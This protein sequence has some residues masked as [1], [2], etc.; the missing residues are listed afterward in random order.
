MSIIKLVP[1]YFQNYN[2]VANPKKTFM[3]SSSGGTTGSINLFANTS[4]SLKDLDP[5]FAIAE[6]GFDDNFIDSSRSRIVNIMAPSDVTNGLGLMESYLTGVNE[7]PQG[8][9]QNKRQEV[10]RFIPGARLDKN[11]GR[12]ATIQKILY[13][14]YQ[15]EYQNLEWAYTN[16]NCLHFY[17]SDSVPSDSALIYPAGTGA[18]GSQDLNVYAPSGSFTFD[19]YFKPKV[20][21]SKAPG[22]VYNPGTILHMSSCYAISAVSGTHKGRDGLPNAFRIL[23]QLSQSA[24]VA[25]SSCVIGNKNVTSAYGD[26][27]LMFATSDNSLP[28]DQWSHVSI[29]WPGKLKNGGTGSIYINGK[30]DT[31]FVI[32]SGSVMQSYQAGAGTDDPNALF[33]GNYYQGKNFG[34]EAIARYFNSKV[35]PEQGLTSFFTSS[36]PV[37]EDPGGGV[38]LAHPL[39]GELHEIKIY[40][41]EKSELEI[42]RMGRSGVKITRDLL[43]YVP[44]FFVQETR[45]RN[46]LQTPFFDATGSSEDPF[47]IALSFGVGGREINLENFSREFIRKEYPRLHNL[48]SSRIDTSVQEEGRT[49]NDILYA[50]GSSLKRLFTILPCDNGKLKP[51]FDILQT[52]SFNTTRFV[53][54]FGTQ[55]YDLID[56]NNMVDLSSY[57]VGL[58][59]VNTLPARSISGLGSSPVTME[60]LGGDP[61]DIQY[62]T[63]SFLFDLTGASPEDPSVSPGNILTIAQRTGDPSSNEVVFFDASNIF[64]GD[65]INPGTVLIEDTSPKGSDGSFKLTLRDNKLG[66][67]YRCDTPVS[68]AA[69]WS[70][71]GNVLYEEGI[72]VI[73]SPHLGFFGKDEF[74]ITFEGERTVYVFEVSIPVKSNLFNS[75][76]NPQYRDLF[77]TNDASETSKKFSYI[78]GVNLHDDN[79][80]VVGKATLSQPFVKREGDK[81]VI[82]LR[83]DY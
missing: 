26:T 5:T 28:R 51:N 16:F 70:S 27:G 63:G 13:P 52:G 44:P 18:F 66:N 10:L 76:S 33:V 61:A 19:F 56:M 75:S 83:M 1:E 45:K 22:S 4:P 21:S 3:S 36:L 53:D 46:I 20:N 57:P 67:I 30:R 9:R 79:F 29:T 69:S 7:H 60:A 49:A 59:S 55:R 12:K 31:D 68:G 6:E 39:Q 24:D 80:N 43:F 2:L 40:N 23:F 74:R 50:S 73:K 38:K 48:T 54:S 77:P 15:A 82:K 34:N 62:G 25:P 81:V 47:N 35:S 41:T 17:E 78:T 37:S 72:I 71:V 58:K 64:Y 14:Y 42:R 32:N 8:E 11:H 65:R